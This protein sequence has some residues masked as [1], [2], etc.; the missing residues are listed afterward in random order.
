MWVGNLVLKIATF[1]SA[2]E[3]R[4]CQVVFAP[5][6]VGNELQDTGKGQCRPRDRTVQPVG[7]RRVQA[8]S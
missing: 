6:A 5:I 3:K 4:V 8:V 7:P 1:A 2:L